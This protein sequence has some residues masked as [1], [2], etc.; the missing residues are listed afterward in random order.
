GGA[1]PRRGAPRSA[2]LPRAAWTERKADRGLSDFQT[3]RSARGGAAVGELRLRGPDVRPP[4]SV[5]VHLLRRRDGRLSR[6]LSRGEEVRLLR[7][8][9]S[10][11]ALGAGRDEDREKQTREQRT[12]D[13][14]C[15]P[16]PVIRAP[17]MP[18]D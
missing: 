17:R 8:S 10:G 4:A 9:V 2:R 15:E 13:L 1:P 3:A 16:P 7:R 6:R 14:H 12:C 11:C 18:R 5:V